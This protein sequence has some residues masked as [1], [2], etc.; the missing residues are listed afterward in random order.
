MGSGK[1]FHAQ[2]EGNLAAIASQI[3]AIL[4]PGS[5]VAL[6]GDLGMGKTALARALMADDAVLEVKQLAFGNERGL[7]LIRCA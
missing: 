5:I 4:S 1:V 7:R 6:H 2:N 3:A